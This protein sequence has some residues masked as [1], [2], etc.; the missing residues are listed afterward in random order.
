VLLDGHAIVVEAMRLRPDMILMDVGMPLLN[1]LDA[2]WRIKEQA[3][4]IKF[5]LLTMRGVPNLA[6]A[7]LELGPIGFGLKHSTGQELLKRRSITS[8]RASLI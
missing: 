2:A 3:A 5:I 6:A 8:C 1:G 7:A 4:N